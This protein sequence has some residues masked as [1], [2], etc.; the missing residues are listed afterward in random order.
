[1]P[2][3]N[4]MNFKLYAESD[5]RR[6]FLKKL[7]GGAAAVA[8]GDIGKV[9]DAASKMAP[10]VIYLDLNKIASAV[11]DSMHENVDM[12]IDQAY[13]H[14]N[15]GIRDTKSNYNLKQIDKKVTQIAINAVDFVMQSIKSAYARGIVDMSFFDSFY[16]LLGDA[17]R[18]VIADNLQN[19]VSQRSL[20]DLNVFDYNNTLIHFANGNTPI[21]LN[22]AGKIVNSIPINKLEDFF[23]TYGG[24]NPDKLLSSYNLIKNKVYNKVNQFANTIKDSKLLKPSKKH[25]KSTILITLKTVLAQKIYNTL[26]QLL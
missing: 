15:L 4:R 20:Q 24:V 10:K 1:M 17:D 2:I 23:N 6:D 12:F 25:S 11:A 7:V 19:I 22:I 21:N 13:D 16:N 5:T 3:N 8:K 26:N 18:D 14:L 9:V